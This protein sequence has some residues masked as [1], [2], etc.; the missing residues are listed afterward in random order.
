M[1]LSKIGNTMAALKRYTIHSHLRVED[2]LTF[3]IF[4]FTFRQTAILVFGAGIAYVLWNHLP[5]HL[6]LLGL[7]LPDAVLGGVHVG[8][9]GILMLTA[10][11]LAFI[12]RQGRTL[13]A[14]LVI[15]LRYYGQPRFYKWR[16]L[17]DP[18]L[19]RSAPAHSRPAEPEEDEE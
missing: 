12:R 15:W 1:A 8:V 4:V 16:R 13:D 7:P 2:K 5:D 6:M 14:W 18:A 19:L 9:V 11:A 3:G 17:P 10:L